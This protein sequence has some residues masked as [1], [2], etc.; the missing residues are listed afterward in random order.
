MVLGPGRVA[1]G[2]AAHVESDGRIMR[3]LDL[4][5]RTGRAQP[6]RVEIAP[7]GTGRVLAGSA[8]DTG[9]LLAAL[10]VIPDMTGGRL[11][12]SGH[13]D[14]TAPG[15]PLTGHAEIADFRIRHAPALAK[16]LQ[17]MTLY[18]LVDLMQ[19]PGLGFTR[20]IAPFRLSDDILELHDARAFSPSLGMTAKGRLDLA[21]EAFDMQGT[22]VP[23]YFF[24][25]LLGNVP[26][27][28]R[29]FSPERGGGLF[30]ATYTL[31]GPL[32]DPSV[33]VN[34]L[35]ALTPGFLR[36]VFGLLDRAATPR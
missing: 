14:D 32:A 18:G 9:A 35:A 13:Y 30:A 20:L 16:L 7:Q 27:V 15:H 10:D 23:A 34:P 2:I 19:G 21:R 1:T 4:S 33:S 3:R 22:I 36:G 25:S 11:A 31:R 28:G 12:L 6:F 17:A 29:L 8:A 26:L 24:N 5:G